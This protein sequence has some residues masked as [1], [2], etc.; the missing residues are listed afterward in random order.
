MS[1]E[2]K[3]N[4]MISAVNEAFKLK[5]SE[6]EM[7]NNFSAQSKRVAIE[8]CKNSS[9]AF[10]ILLLGDSRTAVNLGE[11]AWFSE[12]EDVHNVRLVNEGPLKPNMNHL[13]MMR[14]DNPFYYADI[15]L[16]QKIVQVKPNI[17]HSIYV[18]IPI[19]ETLPSGVYKGKIKVLVSKMF[20][21]EETAGEITYTITVNDVCLPKDT[22][23]DFYLDLW[24]H[25]SNIARKAEVE[26]WSDRHFEIIEK[27]VKTLSDLGQCAV[28]VTVTEIPWCGQRCFLNEDTRANLFE[29]SMVRVFENEDGSFIYDYSALERY[30]EL[31]FSYGIDKEIEVFGLLNIWQSI[32]EG[33][34]NFTNYYDALRIRYKRTDGIY[35]YMKKV[36]HI[37][38]YI[39][40]LYQFFMAKGWLDKVRV[41]ADEPW[42]KES[43]ELSLDRLSKL[44]PKFRY[45]VALGHF[46]F[47]DDFKDRISDFAAGYI[48]FCRENDK[49]QKALAED[50]KSKFIWYTCCSPEMP[51]NFL[52]SN[53]LETRYIMVLND[54]F[55][56][57]GFLRW[58]Y[59]V[60]P[61]KPR[62]DIRFSMF[63]AGDTNFVYPAGDMSP[64]LTLRYK[65]LKRG[66]EDFILLKQIRKNGDLKTVDEI[67]NLIIKNTDFMDFYEKTATENKIGFDKMSTTKFSDW[68][69]T[70]NLMYLSILNSQNGSDEK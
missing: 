49:F 8:T 47:Y 63:A 1:G 37:E 28:T 26:L 53:L 55:G 10:Q 65:A 4:L 34:Y 2:N 23:N 19:P 45:K 38:D 15:L 6:D 41:T 66:I 64:L 21:T 36:K 44:C 29:Y 30:I 9:A 68:E 24:Q 3:V 52:R 25:N 69:H 33:Y 7:S 16:N 58:D 43:F 13:G 48:C 22:K 57:D 39:K 31:C 70:R 61:E 32:N 40:S 35:C 56:L 62:E 60:W 12:Y 50:K 46:A 20:E 18:E 59:T 54:Y 5:I 11:D 51:N 67:H 14:D 42:E 27:Y 17:P